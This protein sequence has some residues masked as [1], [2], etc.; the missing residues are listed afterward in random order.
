VA[1]LL[2]TFGVNRPSDGAPRV[3]HLRFIR[4]MQLR[5]FLL[6]L[7]ALLVRSASKRQSLVADE[8]PVW[9]N[10]EVRRQ[11]CERSPPAIVDRDHDTK[12]PLL[13]VVPDHLHLDLVHGA[14]RTGYLLSLRLSQQFGDEMVVGLPP[15]TIK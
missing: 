13:P 14:G 11:R 6:F 4:D 2:L 15:E 1:G 9:G 12:V 7:P 10:D 8:R 5:S 3:D